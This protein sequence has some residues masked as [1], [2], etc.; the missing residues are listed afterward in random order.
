MSKVKKNQEKKTVKRVKTSKLGVNKSA[1]LSTHPK[2]KTTSPKAKTHPEVKPTSPKVITHPKVTCNPVSATKKRSRSRTK[3]KSALEIT[4]SSM[5]HISQCMSPAIQL[6]WLQLNELIPVLMDNRPL[7]PKEENQVCG[8]LNKLNRQCLRYHDDNKYAFDIIRYNGPEKIMPLE[9]EETAYSVLVKLLKTI[10]TIAA[11]KLGNNFMLMDRICS[12]IVATYRN[13]LSCHFD[14]KI[15]RLKDKNGIILFC[16]NKYKSIIN[17][18][19]K[20]MSDI[21]RNRELQN[22]IR[23]YITDLP[24][25]HFAAVILDALPS[26]HQSIEWTTHIN[27]EINPA[28][29]FHKTQRLPSPDSIIKIGSLNTRQQAVNIPWDNE[30]NAQET[31]MPESPNLS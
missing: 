16:L 30:P 1:S 3:R 4:L 29:L 24:D 23:A 7:P 27:N 18:S 11:K 12:I 15:T 17:E 28:S 25:R 19:W 2:V 26:D 5:P 14:E 31:V 21:D 13:L 9:V 8:L 10:Q 22:W 6:F 20:G